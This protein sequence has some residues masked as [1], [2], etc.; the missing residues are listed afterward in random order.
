MT[1]PLSAKVIHILNCHF[2]THW[3]SENLRERV[4]EFGEDVANQAPVNLELLDALA[5]IICRDCYHPLRQHADEYGCEHDMGDGYVP[6]LG[7]VAKGPCHCKC[8]DCPDLQGAIN[9]LRKI[10]KGGEVQ[11]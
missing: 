7:E 8:E 9:L 4:I 5:G 10:A 3:A 6:D 1:S 2:P 11:P